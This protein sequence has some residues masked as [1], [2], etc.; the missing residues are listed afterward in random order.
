M[1]LFH[2]QHAQL[3]GLR[4]SR[5]D[6]L[7]TISGG[8]AGAG[9]LGFRDWMTVHAEELRKQDRALILLYMAGG[10]SQFETFDP[11]PGTDNGGPTTAIDTAVPG[12]QI[13]QHWP[14][15]AQAMGDIALIRSMTNR[16]GQHQRAA[17]Q[18]HTGYLPSGSVKYP[19]LG[20]N[21][22]RELADR[23][24][25]LPAVVSVGPSVGAGF[26]GVDFEP[27]VVQ[28][29]GQLPQ[30]VAS[31]VPVPRFERRLGLLNRLEGEFAER[32]GEQAVADH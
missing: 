8:A 12:I 26:L 5:R 17:Y 3:D 10:P 29:P 20:C 24:R 18:L 13:A 2:L 31:A 27:F 19:S 4:V 25:D 23:S 7:R 11:K 28:N 22:A 15:V 30:D 14:R 16:E 1:S 32:G 21:L 9:L 6:F